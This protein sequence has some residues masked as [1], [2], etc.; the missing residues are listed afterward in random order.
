MRECN[1]KGRAA[2]ELGKIGRKEQGKL[3]FD[4]STITDRV[5]FRW[6]STLKNSG[7]EPFPVRGRKIEQEFEAEV[8]SKLMLVEV[9][10]KT[11]PNGEYGDL[12][13]VANVA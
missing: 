13:V 3:V 12:R 11:G 9:V 10:K 6:D 7:D 4:F 1:G 2:L 8:I 5:L